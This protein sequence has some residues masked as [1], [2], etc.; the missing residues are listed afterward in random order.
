MTSAILF[1]ELFDS[2]LKLN[3]SIVDILVEM[4]KLRRITYTAR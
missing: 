1:Y 2:K 3:G 4:N